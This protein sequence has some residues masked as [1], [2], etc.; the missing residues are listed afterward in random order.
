MRKL[1][2]AAAALAAAGSANAAVTIT[3]GAYG[4]LAPQQS[5]AYAGTYAG[6]LRSTRSAQPCRAPLVRWDFGAAEHSLSVDASTTRLMPRC[7]AACST[8]N[9]LFTLV[10]NVSAGGNI[11]LSRIAAR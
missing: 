10:E 11:M 9:V 3:K 7:T 1:L 8:L 2:I 4:T 5:R 6:Q